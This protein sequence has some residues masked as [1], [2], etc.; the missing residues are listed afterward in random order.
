MIKNSWGYV[1]GLY[2]TYIH[3]VNLYL[4]Q[5][6]V[7]PEWSCKADV[8]LE[9][10]VQKKNE[11]NVNYTTLKGSR[12]K[13]CK[14]VHVILWGHNVTRFY[15]FDLLFPRQLTV[16]TIFLP[17]SYHP[18]SQRF[19]WMNATCKSLLTAC[20]NHPFWNRDLQHIHPLR[21][22]V[23]CRSSSA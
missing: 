4:L 21:M 5:Q 13:I 3:K 20:T 18:L 9:L 22:G 7:K 17:P 10:K 6:V 2:W 23:V 14:I 1:L 11:K 12:L 15:Y 8:D 19:S 16:L